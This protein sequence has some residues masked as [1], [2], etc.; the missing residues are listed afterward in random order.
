MKSESIAG[1]FQ[2]DDWK[3]VS[4]CFLNHYRSPELLFAPKTKK[5]VRGAPIAKD[6]IAKQSL[7][8]KGGRQLCI[9]LSVAARLDNVF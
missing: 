3:G 4:V 7:N 1:E 2:G 5:G 9:V 6:I 8:V